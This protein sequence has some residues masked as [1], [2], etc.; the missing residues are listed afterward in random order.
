MSDSGAIR[1]ECPALV[2]LLERAFG[3]GCISLISGDYEFASKA[4]GNIEMHNLVREE[5]VSFRPRLARI[6][7]LLLQEIP[8]VSLETARAAL[9]AA[10]RVQ[11]PGHGAAYPEAEAIA[12]AIEL[13]AVRH[14]HMTSL[15]AGARSDAL[16]KSENL[17]RS[18]SQEDALEPLRRKLLHAITL[19]RRRLKAGDATSSELKKSPA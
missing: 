10:A 19:Q 18:I 2:I 6:M 11:P 16:T 14:L 13:D 5:G 4:G 9:Y 8:G 1:V 3:E 17:E 7:S 12:L 15:D